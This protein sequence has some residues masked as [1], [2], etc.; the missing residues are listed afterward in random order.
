MSYKEVMEKYKTDKP[1]LR[2]DKDDKDLL[3][4]LWILDFPMFEMREDGSMSAMHHPFTAMAEE[5]IEKVKGSTKDLLS[6]KAKQYNKALNGHEVFGGSIRT[7]DAEILSQVFGVLGH[8][9]NEIKD[10]FGHL[11]EA[12][13]YGVPPHGGIAASDRWFMAMT[14]AESIR[15]VVAFPTGGTGRTAVMDAPSEVDQSQLKELGLMTIKKKK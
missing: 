4:Y 8:S 11:L 12:F 1:D 13:S 3:A 2:K 7:H 5:D 15:E 14:G 6:I 9:E 10:R